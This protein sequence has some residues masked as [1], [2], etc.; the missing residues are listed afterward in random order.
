M[1]LP[2]RKVPTSMSVS[3]NTLVVA[4]HH[5]SGSYQYPILV[6]PEFWS[7]W[8]NLIPENWG[9][10]EAG[11]YAYSASSSGLWLYHSGAFGTNDF[12]AWTEWT[13]GYTKLYY[14]YAKY[15]LSAGANGG[16][17]ILYYSPWIELYNSGSETARTYLLNGSEATV[18]AKSNCSPEGVSNTNAARLEVTTTEP[19]QPAA[20]AFYVNANQVATA[21]AEEKGKHSTVKYNTSSGELSVEGK[22]TANV[23]SGA[24]GWIGPHSGAFEFTAEDGGLGIGQTKVEY[25]GSSAWETYGGQNYQTTSACHGVQCG[26]VQHETYTYNGL[27]EKNGKKALSEPEAKV[28]VAASSPMP[29]AWS[30]EY[31]EG[32]ATLKVDTKSPRGITLTGLPGKEKEVEIGEVEAHLKVEASDGEGSIPSSGMRSIGVEIDGHEI[33]TKG[34][35]CSPGP[36]TSSGEWSINGAGLGTGAHELTVAAIDNAGNIETK[37]YE[38]YVHA[39]SPVA[40]GPGSVNPESGDFAMEATDVNLSG[41]MGSLEV[42]RHYDSRNLAEG[43]AGPLGPQ[44]TI[45]LGN[46]A[47]LEVLPDRSVMVV[48]ASGLTHFSLKQGGGF[49]APEGDKNLTLEYEP[50][51]PAYLLKNSAQDTTIEFTL[52]VGAESWMP[53]VSKGPVTTDTTTDEYKTIEMHEGFEIKKM[54]EP[55]LELAP[56]PTATCGHKELENLEITAKGCRALEFRYYE[57][58]TA[59]GEAKS[60]WGGYKN[61]L[62]EILVVA[63]N[64]STKAMARTAVAKYEYDNRDR[65]RAEWNPEVSP[66]LQTIYGYDSEG[67]ITSV[68]SPGQQPWLLHYGAIPSDPNTGRLLAT[69]RPS[70]PLR[71]GTAEHWLIQPLPLYLPRAQ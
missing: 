15:E 42:T 30:S 51:T 40:L 36:C 23:F 7:V 44:W 24:G 3:G 61:D 65:L 25:K 53:T 46:L 57:E 14:M 27:T 9:I 28:R 22:N 69:I 49:E 55:V 21:I 34:G 66:A 43:K 71:R 59:K 70:A 38:L 6:D 5:Q 19:S 58:T 67:H 56:H 16:K 17:G 4:V 8:L 1:M 64:P 62:K 48:G 41:G 37:A 50:K 2:G 45:G 20:P 10:S 52:P 31:G 12:G 33:G 47:S 13:E 68:A 35:F 26:P 32:E 11:G 39:A 63:Y 29:Y 60:E 18:C 54:V